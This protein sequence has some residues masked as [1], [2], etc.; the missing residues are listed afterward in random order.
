MV[1]IDDGNLELHNW[2]G[3]QSYG[4]IFRIQGLKSSPKPPH[5]PYLK[6]WSIVSENV[7]L[8][9]VSFALKISVFAEEMTR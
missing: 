5:C 7:T 2:S 6:R 3:S 8:Q 9:E 1:V 4:T